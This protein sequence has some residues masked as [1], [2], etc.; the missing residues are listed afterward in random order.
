MTSEPNVPKASPAKVAYHLEQLT[1]LFRRTTDR[2]F[3][4]MFWAIDALRS[5]RLELAARLANIPA[6]GR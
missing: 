2:Q 3:L 6:P 5:G 4:Q 1:K